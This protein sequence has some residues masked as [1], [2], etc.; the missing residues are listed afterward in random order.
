[1]TGATLTDSK[2]WETQRA[3]WRIQGVI[4]ECA[5]WDKE[6]Q[7]ATHYASGEF[8]RLYSE[9]TTIELFYKGGISTFELNTLPALLQHLAS[10]HP[11]ANIQL[12]TIEQT[13]GGAKITIN[14]GDA[15]EETKQA[16]QTDA[17]QVQ[18]IQL[19]LRETEGKR[20][21]LEA[22]FNRMLETFTNALLASVPSQI[23]FH[24][25][26]H[27]AALPS[28]N[29]TVELHQTFND[30]TEL[31]QLIDKLLTHN[32]ALTAPQY[33]EIGAAK[34]ELQKPTPDKSR[35]TST[36]DFLKSLP[37]E[38][39]LKGVGKLGEKAAEADWSNLLHQLGELIHH[40]R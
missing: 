24:A 25:P 16:I 23:H 32:A 38:A 22:N 2:L 7:T 30:T 4:C 18:R 1:L 36:L 27:T 40:L 19:S 10:K 37:K 3:G 28:G 39:V 21:Q 12:K 35:L 5:Y 11:D 29:A 6:A 20:L 34:T 14:L 31:I 13:G 8:E 26:V 33:A 15:N 17:A 9:Q